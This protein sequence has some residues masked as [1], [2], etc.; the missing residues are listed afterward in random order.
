MPYGLSSPRRLSRKPRT[1]NLVGAYAVY[2]NT[3]IRPAADDT[4]TM[5]P[6]RAPEHVDRTERVGERRHGRVDLPGIG[7]VG[8]RD[9]DRSARRAKRRR[10]FVEHVGPPR[11]Q[12]DAGAPVD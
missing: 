7:D 2:P 6:R 11:D 10:G 4:P 12:R 8:R 3:P 1:A 9:R 5:L